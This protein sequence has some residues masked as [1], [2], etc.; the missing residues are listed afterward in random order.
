M[1]EFIYDFIFINA[2]PLTQGKKTQALFTDAI[3][4]P[5]V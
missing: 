1:L 4:K 3:S 5:T 2:F